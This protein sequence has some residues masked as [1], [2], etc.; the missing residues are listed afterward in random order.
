MFAADTDILTPTG[1]KTLAE[2]GGHAIGLSKTQTGY[3]WCPLT[4]QSHGLQKVVRI[5]F[6]DYHQ[7]WATLDQQWLYAQCLSPFRVSP[8]IRKSLGLLKL[9][10]TQLPLAPIILPE[11]F[12]QSIA[13]GFVFGDGYALRNYCRVVVFNDK[14][15]MVPLL[16][17]FGDVGRVKRE[18]HYRPIVD[19]LPKHWKQIPENCSK[20]YA[21]GFILGIIQSDGHVEGTRCRLNSGF[22]D[23]MIDY[24]KLAIYA[25]LRG[26]NCIGSCCI[27]ENTI[28]VDNKPRTIAAGMEY[29]WSMK[30]YNLQK[31]HF[32]RHDQRAKFVQRSFD[33]ATRASFI[34]WENMTEQEV[35]SVHSPEWFNY[36]L[37][38]GL[39]VACD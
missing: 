22:E 32:I 8:T 1:P 4:L 31:S 20:E 19:N 18:G 37:S 10:V 21:F 14:E 27:P 26:S 12:E 5:R 28:I 24:R 11:P 23:I 17:K 2:L 38:N 36:T 29:R 7:V 34:D 30:T 13:H 9:N 33:L 35:Y 25:G 15:A 6:G 16:S 3:E 39:V